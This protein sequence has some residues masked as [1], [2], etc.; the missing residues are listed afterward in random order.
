MEHLGA[1]GSH[2]EP[3]GAIWSSKWLQM[4]PNGSEGPHIPT[5]YRYYLAHSDRWVP[6]APRSHIGH[7]EPFWVPGAQKGPISPRNTATIW[8]ILTGGAH[9]ANMAIL[10]ILAHLGSK[11]LRRAPK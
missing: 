2:L 10:A 6:G 1:P 3:F 8:P 7:S 9:M 11:V 4:A 5:K